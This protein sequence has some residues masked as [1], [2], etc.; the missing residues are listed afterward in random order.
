MCATKERLEQAYGRKDCE[1]CGAKNVLE[2]HLCKDK[3]PHLTHV[4]TGCGRVADAEEKLCYPAALEEATKAKWKEIPARDSQVPQCETC[5]QPVEKPGHVCDPILPYT[6]EHCGQEVTNSMHM[7]EGIV[8]NA[9]YR[10]NLC[11]RVAVEKDRLC[12][13]IELE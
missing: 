12:A 7:C 6:C 3:I 8:Q 13:P 1:Y 4:C 10:C 9:K 5:K 11:D 2:T